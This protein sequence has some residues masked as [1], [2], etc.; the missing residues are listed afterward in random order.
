MEE[1]ISNQE[2]LEKLNQIQIDLNII[3]EKLPE[4]ELDVENQLEMGLD[5]LRNGKIVDL[6]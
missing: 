2:I 1:Q 6:N 4:D 3:K 5:D